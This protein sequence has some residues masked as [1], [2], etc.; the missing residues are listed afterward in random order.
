M[1][2]SITIN[3]NFYVIMVGHGG[4]SWWRENPGQEPT[5]W[6]DISALTF[7]PQTQEA[8]HGGH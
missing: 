6:G 2:T 1:I 7:R 5:V 3:G 4:L 8:P